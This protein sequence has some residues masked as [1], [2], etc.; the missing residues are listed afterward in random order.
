MVVALEIQSQS[1][2]ADWIIN[3]YSKRPTRNQTDEFY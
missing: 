1:R 2:L 3:S